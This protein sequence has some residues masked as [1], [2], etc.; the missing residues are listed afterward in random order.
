MIS[1]YNFSH[2][3]FCKD[4]A[5]SE[6]VLAALKLKPTCYFLT[7]EHFDFQRSIIMNVYGCIT[8]TTFH[9]EDFCRD[10]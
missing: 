7:F 6:G 1:I 10:D 3:K 2:L 9:F 8:Q 5:L 4:V